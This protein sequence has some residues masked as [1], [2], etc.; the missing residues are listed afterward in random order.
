MKWHLK[1]FLYHYTPIITHWQ[2]MR[3]NRSRRFNWFIL[4]SRPAE[5]FAMISHS[6][7][8]LKRLG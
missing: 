1:L 5:A 6:A 4:S 7:M 3:Q 8:L 2:Q